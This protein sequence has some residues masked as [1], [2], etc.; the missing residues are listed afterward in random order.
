MIRQTSYTRTINNSMYIQ[1]EY[2]NVGKNVISSSK[3]KRRNSKAVLLHAMVL[4]GRTGGIAPT[5]S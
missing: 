4:L 1:S 3:Q 2:E 5:H